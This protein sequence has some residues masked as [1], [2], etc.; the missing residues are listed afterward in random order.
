MPDQD[1]ET[2]SARCANRRAVWASAP[3]GSVPR[4]HSPS[5]WGRRCEDAEAAWATNRRSSRVN[6][7]GAS[8]RA[9]ASNLTRGSD[10]SPASKA[11]RVC[12]ISWGEA[13]TARRLRHTAAGSPDRS[14]SQAVVEANPCRRATPRRSASAMN[15]ARRASIREARRPSRRRPSARSESAKPRTGA[16]NNSDRSGRSTGGSVATLTFPTYHVPVTSPAGPVCPVEPPPFGTEA[17][18]WHDPRMAPWGLGPGPGRGGYRCCG[19]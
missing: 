5:T 2:C 10:T 8:Q 13:A 1:G 12:G 19:D 14:I 3:S 17:A 6:C 16:S 7:S 11:A 18:G 4:R 9:S 15:S